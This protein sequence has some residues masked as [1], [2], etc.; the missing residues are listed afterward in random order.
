MFQETLVLTLAYI[1]IV[2]IAYCP[3]Q[4]TQTVSPVGA[5]AYFPEIIDDQPVTPSPATDISVVENSL[6]VELT[7]IATVTP[8]ET[9]PSNELNV[10]ATITTSPLPTDLKTLTSKELK[11]IARTQKIPKYGSLTKKA[12]ILAL[13]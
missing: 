8:L 7:A 3:S 13:T 2:A 11:A 5:I 4:K 12:L 9:L 10:I 1:L 6:P